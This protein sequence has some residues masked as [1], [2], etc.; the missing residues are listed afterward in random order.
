MDIG[1]TRDALSPGV[2][3]VERHPPAL[4]MLFFT[5][6]WERFSFY[7]MRALLVLYLVNS[8]DYA[9]AD[10]LALY[11]MYTG[12][13][14]LTPIAGGWL[15]DR[16]LGYRK[17]ILIG[18]IV[19]AAG[20]FAMAFPSLLALALG[21]LIVGNGFFKP[22]ISTLLGTLY[23]EH[24]PRRDGGFTIFYM[25]INLGALL[26][27]L[28]AGTL[29]EKIGWHW[30]FASAGVGM[31]LALAQFVLQQHKLGTAGLPA[32]KEKLDARDWFQVALVSA[33][34]VPL[35]YGV[36]AAWDAFGAL[37]SGLATQIKIAVPVAAFIAFVAFQRRSCSR[38]EWHR[39]L[40]IA[41]IGVFE[42]F[43]WMGFEQAGGT[44]NLFADRQTDRLLFGW[45][46]PTS[47]FQGVN[48][49]IIVL[50]GP[51]FALMWRRWDQ[52][53][54]ALPTAAKMGLGMIILGAGFVV[55]AI[56][57]DR[58]DS[59]G[60]VGPQWLLLVYLLHTV[61]E[62]CLSPIGL[63]MVTKLAPARLAAVMMG[64]WF[65]A[66]AIA[67]Y[68]AGI[69]ESLLAGSGIPLYWFLVG[70]SAGAGVLLLLITPLLERLMHGKT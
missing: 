51:L 3:A 35:V 63:S 27:P 57:Q 62:L 23:R 30:G 5:E 31:L 58:A 67:N 68:L 32:G 55:L 48:P 17:A 70:S 41:I 25:G 64:I 60:K 6:M 22:N 54:F 14:Y 24:D 37:W 12:L 20:H 50:L 65:T 40:A 38:E 21:L 45:E 69:L 8:L 18:G 44:M 34:M 10:A 11:G 26:S 7:G 39:V 43:F 1:V 49:L 2:P 13:V 33:L 56:A 29:G 66:S 47:Y 53:R 42:I 16:Y 15:A 28:V 59:L 4:R 46:V 61:G 19:L 52:S 9:R 36:I